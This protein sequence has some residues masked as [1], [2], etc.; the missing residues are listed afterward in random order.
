LALRRQSNR[1]FGLLFAGVFVVLTGVGW[2][3]SGTLWT[4]A[5]ATAAALAAL[6]LLLP[7]L[8]LLP[9][10]LW[11]QLASRIAVLNTYLIVSA[12]FYVVVGPIGLLMKLF[13]RDPMHR[14]LLGEA[15]SYFTPVRRQVTA[16][17]LGDQS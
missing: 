16:E 13:R 14:R 12:I 10:L 6:A 3:F 8:L 17:T 7:G 9:N 4:W 15:D 11:E 2:L 5:L 1:S